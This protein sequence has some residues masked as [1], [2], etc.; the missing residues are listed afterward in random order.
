MKMM[1]QKGEAEPVAAEYRGGHRNAV[2]RYD[3]PPGTHSSAQRWIPSGPPP[4]SSR[5]H[6]ALVPISFREP[7]LISAKR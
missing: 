5:S 3:S 1:E 6:K 4:V 2:W 7:Q